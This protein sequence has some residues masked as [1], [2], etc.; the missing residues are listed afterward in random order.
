MHNAVKAAVA[1]LVT[2]SLALIAAVAQAHPSDGYAPKELPDGYGEPGYSGCPEYDVGDLHFVREFTSPE[3]LTGA[4]RYIIAGCSG[5]GRLSVS[6]WQEVYFML[7]AYY[8]QYRELPDAISA[9]MIA[10]T[11]CNGQASAEWCET[12]KSPITGAYPAVNCRD[13][14]PGQ[15]YCRMLT[16]DEMEMIISREPSFRDKWLRD[17]HINPETGAREAA[18]MLKPVMYLR[19]YGETGVIHEGLHSLWISP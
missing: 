5:P 11:S 7:L 15:V 12:F 17:W 13:F 1:A 6:W 8:T 18:E 9:E 4:E 16:E 2:C 14:A 10:A 19:I 3:M